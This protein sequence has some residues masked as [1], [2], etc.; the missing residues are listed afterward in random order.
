MA[1]K[2]QK[3]KLVIGV[4][5]VD[6]GKFIEEFDTTRRRGFPTAIRKTLQDDGWIV[7]DTKSAEAYDQMGFA[8]PP[9]MAEKYAQIAL[10]T[11]SRVN[12]RKMGA[13]RW[14]TLEERRDFVDAIKGRDLIPSLKIRLERPSVSKKK[15]GGYSASAGP[16]IDLG[17]EIVLPP[18]ILTPKQE[19]GRRKDFVKKG[20]PYKPPGPIKISKVSLLT[21]TAKMGCASFSLPAG[22]IDRAGTC[23]MASE[24]SA[25]D[26][27]GKSGGWNG[28][29]HPSLRGR[30]RADAYICD[31]CYAGKNNYLQYK[32]I[33]VAQRVRYRWATEAL[34]AGRFE[35]EIIRVIESIRNPEMSA[36]LLDASI[37]TN[38]FRIHDSGD[39]FKER[40]YKAWVSVAEHFHG[41]ITFWAPTRQWTSAKLRGWFSSTPRPDNFIIRPSGLFIGAEAPKIEELDAGSMSLPAKPGDVFQ[42][43]AYKGDAAGACMKND[44]GRI[45]RHCWDRGDQEVNYWTH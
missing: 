32:T 3:A 33:A 31:L 44:S 22:P 27:E 11:A 13:E 41:D 28:H 20:E 36:R 37:D 45:C 30:D 42:C 17:T 8:V 9:A 16:K 40:Y 39:F 15:K 19:E 5:D 43:P 6:V 4:Y 24:K 35:D 1:A 29:I 34:A 21:W 18:S 12:A 7:E 26:L 14:K 38:Y 25:A 23:M 2:K 10:V